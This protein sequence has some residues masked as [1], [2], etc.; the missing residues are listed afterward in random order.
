M[1]LPKEKN[2]MEENEDIIEEQLL[3]E[4]VSWINK[5]KSMTKSSLP[6]AVVFFRLAWKYAKI[7]KTPEKKETVKRPPT[8]WNLFVKEHSNKLAAENPKMKLSERFAVLSEM[9]AKA[10]KAGNGTGS[11]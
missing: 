5:Y 3:S 6:D 4:L 1:T 7:K 11:V 10:K 2:A 8:P 9:Y